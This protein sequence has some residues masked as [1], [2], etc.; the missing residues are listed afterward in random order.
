MRWNVFEEIFEE[1]H[2]SSLA[3]G[4]LEIDR[5]NKYTSSERRRTV[6][7]KNNI[8]SQRMWWSSCVIITILQAWLPSL[9][10]WRVMAGSFEY[11]DCFVVGGFA[12]FS[13]QRMH[14]TVSRIH[15]SLTMNFSELFKQTNQLSRFSPNGKYLVSYKSGFFLIFSWEMQGY[16][17]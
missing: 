11:L 9:L 8:Y 5:W 14:W 1:F 15:I 7:R 16:K 3:L 10:L 6:R 4:Y 17:W 2:R 13:P 12:I